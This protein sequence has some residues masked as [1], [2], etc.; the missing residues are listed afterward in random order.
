MIKDIHTKA[1]T[2]M[3]KC[4][5][6]LKHDLTKVRT[7]RASSGLLD[8]VVVNYYGSDTP[9]KQIANVVVEDVRTL[10]ITPWEKNQIQAIEKAIITSDLGLTPNTMGTTIRIN[11][12][13]LTEERRR[14]MVKLIKGE[15]EG[16][17]VAVRNVR[18]DAIEEIKKA[19]KDKLISEDDEKR[20]ET[21]IQKITDK[22][23]ADID[24]AIVAKEK[25]LMVV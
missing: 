7:G 1:Q 16:A 18:R 13:P 25:E 9:L 2:R 14:D 12:P 4:V 8:N 21:D 15:A 11:L 5:D 6:A 22:A 10:T 24:A 19:Q 17:K 23:V 3:T 20:A